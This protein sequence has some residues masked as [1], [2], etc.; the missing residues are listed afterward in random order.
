MTDGFLRVQL[1]NGLLVLLKEIHT[2]PLVSSWIWYRVGSKDEIPGITGI[3]HW[4]EHMQFRGTPKFPG[5]FLD[6]AIARIG[7]YWN[8]MTSQD[9]TAYFL[10]LPA[11][12]VGLALELEADRMVNSLFTSEDVEAERTVIISERQG[13]ENSPFFRLGEEVRAAAFRVH[14]YHH[15]VIGDMADLK[16][17]QRDDLYRHYKNFYVPNN[18]ILCLAGDFETQTML[19]KIRDCFS[20][21]PAGPKLQ[22][23]VRTEPVQGGERRITLEGPGE[24]TLIEIAYHIPE[25]NHQDFY[26]IM[27]LSSLLTGPDNLNMFGDGGISNKTSRLYRALVDKELAVAVYGGLQGTLDPYL[28]SIILIVHPESS[29]DKNLSVLDS[30]IKRLQDEPPPEVEVK[31]AVKQAR[32]LFAYGSESITN[33][34]YWMGFTEIIA[35]Y[36]WFLSYLNQLEKVSSEDVQRVA[37]TYFRRQNRVVGNYYPTNTPIANTIA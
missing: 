6:K 11:K 31:R 7:G 25:A 9:W 34:A 5:G 24:T 4:V 21:V 13:N 35:D 37:Q 32:A 30:E 26:A 33:Q 36:G 27:V 14:A 3:S 18:G 8:A 10:T 20:N 28:F 12:D 22:R 23:K 16:T 29:V 17:I 19:A 15:E 2:A 1:E